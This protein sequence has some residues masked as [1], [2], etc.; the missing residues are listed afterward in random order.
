MATVAPLPTSPVTAVAGRR[1][2]GGLFRQA[3]RLWRTRIGLVLV[4]VLVFIAIFGHYFAPFGPTDF[5]GAPNQTRGG[6]LRFGADQLSI[7]QIDARLVVRLEL[8]G[9]ERAPHCCFDLQAAHNFSI[10]A[11]L[12]QLNVSSSAGLRERQRRIGIAQKHLRPCAVSR[13]QRYADADADVDLLSL[14]LERF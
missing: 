1:P 8:A 2:P 6:D 13:K 14:D 10:H 9:F 12:E 5:A 3:L 11:R 4:A 7:F